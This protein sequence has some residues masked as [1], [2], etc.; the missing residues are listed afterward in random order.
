MSVGNSCSD[1]SRKEYNI[2]I[3]TIIFTTVLLETLIDARILKM[4]STFIEPAVS[5][6]CLQVSDTASFYVIKGKG[7]GRL[8]LIHAMKAYRGSRFIELP[9]FNLGMK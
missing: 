6:L 7:K 4:T 5:L 3:A 1:G 8:D 2:I 9:I